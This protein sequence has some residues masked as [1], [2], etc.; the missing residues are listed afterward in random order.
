MAE[1]TDGNEKRFWRRKAP[2]PLF[3]LPVLIVTWWWAVGESG[4]RWF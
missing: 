2:E 1:S 3:V 4:Y